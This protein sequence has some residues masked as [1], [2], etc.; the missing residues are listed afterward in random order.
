MRI[1]QRDKSQP[2]VAWAV[3]S[4]RPQDPTDPIGGLGFADLKSSKDLRA[5]FLAQLYHVEA[6]YYCSQQGYGLGARNSAE[7]LGVFPLFQLHYWMPLILKADTRFSIFADD[8][9]DEFLSCRV[10]SRTSIQHDIMRR[11]TYA[12][13]RIELC[14]GSIMWTLFPEVRR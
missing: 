13:L 2:A 3:D 9:E 7:P 1:L 11:D 6:Y 5:I 4:P 14:S 8:L 10:H 12:N